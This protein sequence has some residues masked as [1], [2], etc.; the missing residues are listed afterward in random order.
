MRS[1]VVCHDLNPLPKCS[2][3]NALDINFTEV[4]S[5]N[6]LLH[7]RSLKYLNHCKVDADVKVSEGYLRLFKEHLPQLVCTETSTPS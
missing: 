4:K 3:L 6:P 7:C 2:E 1:Q 5:L